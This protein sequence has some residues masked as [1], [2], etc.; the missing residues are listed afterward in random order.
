MAWS[1]LFQLEGVGDC[2]VHRN[3]L[4][5]VADFQVSP[6]TFPPPVYYVRQGGGF[7]LE[8][9]EITK[10]LEEEFFLSNTEIGQ[11]FNRSMTA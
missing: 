6:L 3:P 11:C 5:V 1:S 10:K 2:V 8:S 9:F 4:S 7:R